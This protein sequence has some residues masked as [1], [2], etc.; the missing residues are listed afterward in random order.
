MDARD[1]FRIWAM[2]SLTWRAAHSHAKANPS[3]SVGNAP[4]FSKAQ[5]C[6]VHRQHYNPAGSNP[7]TNTMKRRLEQ[8][9]HLATALV[10]G[11]APLVIQPVTTGF[12]LAAL[13]VAMALCVKRR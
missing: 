4:K 13:N 5:K 2:R 10:C 1:I 9:I 12:L 11:V 3:A 8:Y 7:R 6:D